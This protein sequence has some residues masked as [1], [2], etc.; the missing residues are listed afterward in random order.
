MREFPNEEYWQNC[1]GTLLH[2]FLEIDAII[3]DII[4]YEFAEHI[5]HPVREKSLFKAIVE[6]KTR[7]WWQ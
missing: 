6:E 7:A 3:G 2:N 5:L 1:F 4:F